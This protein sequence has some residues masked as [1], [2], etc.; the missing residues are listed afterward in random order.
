[1]SNFLTNWA[2][3]IF[4]ALCGI[5]CFDT[6]YRGLKNKEGK[7]TTCAFWLL[8]GIIF[9]FGKVLP[10]ALT[11]AILCVMGLITVT[12]NL[13]MGEFVEATHEEKQAASEKYKNKIFIPAVTV[14][15]V[16][17]I[18]AFVK[19][20]VVDATTG[21]VTKTSLNGAIMTGAGCVL[22][23]IF[24][25]I[26]CK[27]TLKD[28]REDT[29][30]LLMTVGASSLLPQ[31]LGALQS[32]FNLAGVG[33]VISSIVSGII[34]SGNIVIAVI[35]YCLGMVLFTMIMGNAFA[36]FSVI[37]IGIGYPFLIAQGGDPAII[38]A[39]GMTCGY[40]GTLMT[41]MAANFNIVPCAVLE[42]KDPRW[43][44]IKAQAPIALTLI[45]VHIILMLVLAF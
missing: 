9:F 17:L 21:A 41:P 31:L 8:L 16:A 5:V 11:G 20:D 32:I 26:I 7:Y 34:P 1:M 30:R 42:T 18:L 13:K 3:E 4:Y 19:Y 40:C 24:A 29:S 36:A 39:L 2:P 10:S 35:V 37:T 23:L 27:P 14:G 38:G 45:V 22:A 33:D 44:V 12:G 28:T 6:A 25:I 43:A 15:V